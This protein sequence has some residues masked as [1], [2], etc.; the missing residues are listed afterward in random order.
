MKNTLKRCILLVASSSLLGAFPAGAASIYQ[1][2]D[3]VLFFQK[4]S[5]TAITN[6]V[7]VNLGPATD[8]RGPAVGAND[9]FSSLNFLDISTTLVSAF[10]ADWA[11]QTGIYAG[12]AGIYSAVNNTTVVNGDI[13]RTLY[14]SAPRDSVGTIGNAN[15]VAWV[16][17]GST[18]FTTA[19][20]LIQQQNNVFA[21]FVGPSVVVDPAT[22]LIDD[23]NPITVF[24]GNV[25][26]G[27]AFGTFDGGVQQVGSA[28]T[29]GN[30]IGSFGETGSTEFALDLYRIVP[31]NGR[32]GEIDGDIDGSART[33]TYE[34][35]FTVGTNGQLSFITSVVPEP[36]ALAL[37][38]LAAGSFAL[39]RRRSA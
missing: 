38:G 18:P 29:F 28:G 8:Y 2:G 34:G 1:A 30:F 17:N 9:T 26:Q 24:A 4:L 16:F 7:Y 6:T 33:G 10:G 12:I 27:V 36:S 19:A 22:S 39:R 20:G 32:P 11:S 14:V 37:V 35:T 23:N 13:S 25:S 31:T 3:L 21:G 15:S 5:G